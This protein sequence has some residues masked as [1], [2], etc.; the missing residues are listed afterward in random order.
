MTIV[1]ARH[2]Q[3][4]DLEYAIIC[5]DSQGTI[6]SNGQT[7][8]K[9][10]VQKIFPLGQTLISGSTAN[11]D[12]VEAAVNY[13]SAQSS[14]S[15]KDLPA[16]LSARIIAVGLSQILGQAYW[17]HLNKDTLARTDLIVCGKNRGN[18]KLSLY[19]LDWESLLKGKIPKPMKRGET[20]ILG[21]G[22]ETYRSQRAGM[23]ADS[24]CDFPRTETEGF[25]ETLT[26]LYFIAKIAA[27]NPNIDDNV[28]IGVQTKRGNNIE[29]IVL[30]PQNMLAELYTHSE[31]DQVHHRFDMLRAAPLL[32]LGEGYTS[33]QETVIKAQSKILQEYY[34][35][36]TSCL[37]TAVHLRTLIL[38]PQKETEGLGLYDG[39]HLFIS[40][41]SQKQEMTALEN[42]YADHL[43]NMANLVKPLMT[44]ELTDVH[45]AVKRYH[46]TFN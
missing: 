22:A 35:I 28:Q 9:R 12:M 25:L 15:K 40:P 43:K 31:S 44:G 20:I 17:Q 37:D 34:R 6:R 32:F 1:S 30:A 26:E 14:R 18:D 41:T 38:T 8:E 19:L 11:S 29:T 27:S 16:R 39:R 24:E 45:K 4:R 13:V 7:L 10:L 33:F 36:L 46:A 5:S 42:E 21:S 2:V 23:L 3:S